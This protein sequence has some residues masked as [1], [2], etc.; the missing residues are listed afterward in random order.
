MGTHPTLPPLAPC[1]L[2]VRDE[3]TLGAFLWP[4]NTHRVVWLCLKTAQF[5]EPSVGA[6]PVA[7]PSRFCQ[8]LEQYKNSSSK[9][10]KSLDLDP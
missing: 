3:D 9:S 8:E 4:R 5:V 1:A 10:W 7:V 6:H 2:C